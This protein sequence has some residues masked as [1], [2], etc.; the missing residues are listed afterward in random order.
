[1][2]AASFSLENRGRPERTRE[3]PASAVPVCAFTRARGQVHS[4]AL[5]FQIR[6]E[7]APAAVLR[8]RGGQADRPVG[9]PPVGRGRD[10]QAD[11]AATIGVLI[12]A[13]ASGARR[14]RCRCRS[15]DR[16]PR[17]G[18]PPSTSTAS[19]PANSRCCCRS[20]HALVRLA[21]PARRSSWSLAHL[22]VQPTSAGGVVARRE[23]RDSRNA[24]GCGASRQTLEALSATSTGTRHHFQPGRRGGRMLKT[25]AEGP[26]SDEPAGPRPRASAQTTTRSEHR[27]RRVFAGYCYTVPGVGQEEPACAG[28]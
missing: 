14:S 8:R 15:G 4:V 26:S 28:R 21:R 12:G 13:Q 25:G 10:A 7:P 24:P 23:A 18:H 6:I 27:R 22:E 11:A 20:R 16:R 2:R 19:T 1:M 5:R 3:A 17:G 9:E